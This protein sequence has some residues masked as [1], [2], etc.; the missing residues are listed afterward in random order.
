MWLQRRLADHFVLKPSR[1]TV[2]MFEPAT[3]YF[4]DG[5]FGKIECYALRKPSGEQAS[6]PLK[7]DDG[8]ADLLVLKLPGNQGRAERSTSLPAPLLAELDV[9]VWTWN[10]PGYGQ[11]E[12]RASLGKIP[13]AVLALHQHLASTRSSADTRFLAMGNSLGC[14]S[15]LYL[16]SQ[17]PLDGIVLRNPPPLRKMLRDGDAWWNLFV[18]GKLLAVSLDSPMDAP[19]TAASCHIPALFIQ[20]EN[21]RLVTPAMQ[22]TIFDAY[23]GQKQMLVIRGAEHHSP[24]VEGDMPALKQ[25]IR[26]LLRI[27]DTTTN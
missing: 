13:K 9:E 8:P 19:A 5:P 4:A 7:P 26:R 1:H 21:D 16:G 12:G 25:A 10:P 18:G 14:V 3:Q 22:Q 23:A 6:R 17:V 11:S 15:A 20:S 27:E 24:F 2:D